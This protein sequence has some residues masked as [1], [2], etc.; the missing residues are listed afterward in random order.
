M[1][2]DK[3]TM[4]TE[5]IFSDDRTQ[6]YLLRK[7]WDSKKQSATILMTNPS[8]ADLH[9]MDYTTLYILNNLLRLDFGSVDIV[10]IISTMTTKLVL[11][12]DFNADYQEENVS[13]ILKS[14]ER[15][16]KIIIAWGSR[17]ENNRQLRE[18]Q[19]GLLEQLG[20]FSKKL[21][22]IADR[23]GRTGFHPLA[24]Q[25]RFEWKLQPYIL[26]KKADQNKD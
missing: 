1:H 15:S 23:L 20:P 25:I 7:E 19:D 16:D 12:K 14:A 18:I 21:F 4:K 8:T 10:N 5:A 6:R 22:T 11:Q 9:S 13:Q 3:G 2:T 17:G 24:P 26:K